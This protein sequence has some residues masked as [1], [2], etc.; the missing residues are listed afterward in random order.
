MVMMMQMLKQIERRCLLEGL[1]ST[2][3]AALHEE[4]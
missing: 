4:L 3:P 2:G 1:A